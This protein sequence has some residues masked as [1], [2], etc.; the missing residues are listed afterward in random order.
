MY[1]CVFIYVQQH[2]TEFVRSQRV[3]KAANFSQ[4]VAWNSVA[5]AVPFL[6]TNFSQLLFNG[7]CFL[8]VLPCLCVQRLVCLWK[9]IMCAVPWTAIF[10]SVHIQFVPFDAFALALRLLVFFL[11]L[12]V[13]W[14]YHPFR[15]RWHRVYPVDGILVIFAKRANCTIVSALLL[16]VLYCW[17]VVEN[18]NIFESIAKFHF[19]LQVNS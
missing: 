7:F 5:T 16:C 19:R 13:C 2:F 6:L 17:F 8:S 11:S 18:S 15:L 9:F 4:A 12:S 10:Y 1:V 3:K 14:H